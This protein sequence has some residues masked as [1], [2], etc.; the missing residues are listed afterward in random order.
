MRSVYNV[1]PT[2]LLLGARTSVNTQN[3]TGPTGLSWAN[4][5]KAGA[6]LRLRPC[7][8]GQRALPRRLCECGRLAP[9][10]PWQEDGY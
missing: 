7:S 5:G 8:A 1:V 9:P 2:A 4:A 10:R 6:G 3:V